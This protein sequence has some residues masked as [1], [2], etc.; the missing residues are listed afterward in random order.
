MNLSTLKK[1]EA[2]AYLEKG[3]VIEFSPWDRVAN[4]KQGE[5]IVGRIHLS[6]FGSLYIKG[7]LLETKSTTEDKIYVLKKECPAISSSNCKVYCDK[8]V[9]TKCEDC[10]VPAKM[11]EI[12]TPSLQKASEA[13][14]A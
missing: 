13:K 10:E 2:L 1:E 9:G 4:I 8:P 11:A 7:M 12:E 3:A 14:Q 6:T 5:E